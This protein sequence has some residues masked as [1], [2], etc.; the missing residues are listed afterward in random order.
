MVSH[1][2][3]GVWSLTITEVAIQCSVHRQTPL[4]SC[5]SAKKRMGNG[6]SM[7]GAHT[8]P[9]QRF[10]LRSFQTSG[11]QL[12]QCPTLGRSTIVE[13]WAKRLGHQPCRW[14]ASSTQFLLAKRR[15]MFLAAAAELQIRRVM[16]ISQV[17]IA[18]GRAK[19]VVGPPQSAVSSIFRLRNSNLLFAAPF[20]DPSQ[21]R[22]KVSQSR[23]RQLNALLK[24]KRGAAM[25]GASRATSS[26]RPV[27]NGKMMKSGP[28]RSTGQ[29]GQTDKPE[30]YASVYPTLS[31]PAAA[32][33]ASS[34]TS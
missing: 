19:C 22:G 15:N 23:M 11:E 8:P 12:H 13:I 16:R 26:I 25:S 20:G 21:H 27:V 9:P 17:Q 4:P 30:Q 14:V 32:S 5:R 2:L 34:E 24:Y 3:A 31:L 18:A 1:K 29:A 10:A 6:G 7:C 28:V 33:R